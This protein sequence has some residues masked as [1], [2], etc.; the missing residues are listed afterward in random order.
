MSKVLVSLD[1]IL[2][3]DLKGRIKEVDE[4]IRKFLKLLNSEFS[5]DHQIPIIETIITRENHYVY[6]DD[7]NT[8]T[9]GFKYDVY[10]ICPIG[11]N[12]EPRNYY[13]FR[14]INNLACNCL[15]FHYEDKERIRDKKSN[16]R[17]RYLSLYISVEEFEYL[18]S[19][20]GEINRIS[21]ENDN[22][23]LGWCINYQTAMNC[24]LKIKDFNKKEDLIRRLKD[25]AW[26]D[27]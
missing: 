4:K 13:Y 12:I 17:D 18:L 14:I 11:Q 22:Y 5:L 23:K 19:D 15:Y 20:D 2:S 16:G 1:Q 21:Y 25:T 7:G 3:D 9:D 24:I 10:W 6:E 26:L 8:R 27:S